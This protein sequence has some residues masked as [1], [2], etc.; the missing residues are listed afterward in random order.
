M[1][2]VSLENNGLYNRLLENHRQLVSANDNLKEL[3]RLKSEFLRNINHELR[4]PLTVI[5][6]YLT[7]LLE[8]EEPNSQKVEFLHTIHD[9]SL[10]L[11]GLVEK[12]LD[13]S[14]MSENNLGLQIETGDLAE[15]AT[16]FH[17]DRLPGVA[18]SF[19]EFILE[20]GGRVPLARYDPQRVRQILD[21]LVD[22]SIKF[23]PQGSNLA[24]RV[25]GLVAEEKKWARIRIED[26]GPGIPPER[27]PN[28]FDSFRQG[29]GSHTRTVGGMGMG[30]AYA[31]Q[32]AESMDGK[33]LAESESGQG[34]V[35][36]LL[37]PAA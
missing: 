16:T 6:G 8:Q 29:D 15:L 7:F 11:K 12:L 37:L 27:L 25:D 21:A 36:S 18:E 20:I 24:L 9:E 30:L 10:K 17:R 35:F 28:I 32:L 34:A 26:D 13:F 2:G 4:T 1:L 33:L 23:T 22:N 14:A 5:I 3:D 19:H 31:K